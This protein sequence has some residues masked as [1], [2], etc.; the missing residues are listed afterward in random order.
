MA[1]EAGGRYSELDGTSV[2]DSLAAV[3]RGVTP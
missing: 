1:V 3:A 2:V